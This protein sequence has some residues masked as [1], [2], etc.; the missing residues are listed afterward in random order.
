LEE[1]VFSEPTVK[2]VLK[3]FVCVRLDGRESASSRALKL[4]YGPV[5][6]GNVQNRIVSP[7]GENLAR[8]PTQ[9]DIPSLV[10]YLERWLALYPG[11]EEST[12]EKKPLP[13]FATLHQALN[14]AACD[15]RVLVIV[16]DSGIEPAIRPLAW[17]SEFAGR[18]HFVAADRHD[19]A[20]GQVAYTAMADEA[21]CLVVPDEF[22][23]KGEVLARFGFD[24]SP[25]E[26]L[27]AARA[28][29]RSYATQ[30]EARTLAEKLRR[31]A[32][33]GAP[34]WFY[35]VDRQPT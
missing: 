26:I 1:R 7:S 23:M 6:M 31:H 33:I 24:T 2:A 30:F 3:R 20:L 27:S 13:Y 8:L 10:N 4:K 29:L 14:V 28:A 35:L 17:N 25:D 21:A 12:Q 34:D 18:L 32:D 19:A 22:G 11:E 5:V 15:A 9:F 16:L